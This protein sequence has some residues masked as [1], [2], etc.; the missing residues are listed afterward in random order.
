MQD[1]ERLRFGFGWFGWLT[2]ILAGFVLSVEFIFDLSVERIWLTVV[3]AVDVILVVGFSGLLLKGA[4]RS[5]RDLLR[6][7]I[8]NKFDL[9]LLVIVYSVVFIPRLAAAILIGRI[10][11]V[12]AVSLLDTNVGRRLTSSINLR[13]SQTLAL[14]FILIIFLG[15]ILL[16]FPAATVD[17]KGANFLD[18]IFTMTSAACVAGLTVFDVGLYFTK[19]GQAVILMGIQVGG[20]GIMVLSAAFAVFVGGGL[21]TRRQAG[22]SEI[23]DVRTSKGLKDLIV[24]V[25]A[26][27]AVMEF[28]G[29]LVL[30]FLWGYDFPSFSERAWWSIFHSVSA[31]CNA[32]ISLSPNSLVR[33][34][35]DPYVCGIFMI[36]ITAGGIGFYVIADLTNP[37]V[38]KVKRPLAV[39]NRL[40]VQS[41]VVLTA[42]LLLNAMGMLLFL[43]FEYDGALAGLSIPAKINAS[44]FQAVTLRTTGF[45]TV[46]LANIAIPTIMFSAVFMFVG[47]S[48][49]STGGGIKTTTAAVCFMAVRSMLRGKDRVEMFGRTIPSVIVNRSLSIGL[50]ASLVIVV[51][52]I[53]LSATQVMPFEKLFFEVVSAFGTVGLSMDLTKEFDSVG[54]ILVAIL[55]YIGRIGPLTM[56]LALGERVKVRGIDLPKG[57]IAVG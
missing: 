55:M 51:F 32:G 28:F 30:F 8:D 12:G 14:S 43:F 17:G 57:R 26:T 22:L 6:W 48:P 3:I 5:R 40:H 42:T 39:W 27:T 24:A 54:R 45:S 19:F 20:L 11:I 29:A 1:K 31:F 53:I 25:A 34:V 56:A 47:A 4:L 9:I 46:A 23:L 2:G 7:A 21:P 38:W 13:P 33:W 44:L 41:R 15:G 49:G 10:I 36:L 35:A 50:I 16:T 18:A 52:I 37:N